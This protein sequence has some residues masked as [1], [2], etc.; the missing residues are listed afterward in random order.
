MLPL[1][2][3]TPS[4][5]PFF[6]KLIL[7]SKLDLLILPAKTT[8][9]S[10]ITIMHIPQHATSSSTTIPHQ[11]LT[12][13]PNYPLD[14]ALLPLKVLTHPQLTT[15]DTS[16]LKASVIILYFNIVS[17]ISFITNSTTK[18]THDSPSCTFLSMLPHAQ[19][20]HMLKVLLPK[21]VD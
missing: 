11:S 1:P 17:F 18:T 2:I 4:R 12:L 15:I 13:K 14:T 7:P 3:S 5:T 19:Q 9:D 6:P 10:P 8:H 16:L 20:A 21:I